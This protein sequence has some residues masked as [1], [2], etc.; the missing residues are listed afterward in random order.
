[1]PDTFT[2]NSSGFGETRVLNV[3]AA[4]HYA[5][6][7][8]APPKQYNRVTISVQGR[9]MRADH[10][11]YSCIV[12]AMSPLD[13]VISSGTRPEFGE[14]IV[15]YLEYIGRIEGTVSETG[16][17]SF[18]ISINATDRK[19]DKLSAQ[20]T[21][22]ANKQELGLP[23]D[24]RHERVVPSNTVSEIE[25]DDGSRFP[26]RIIDLSISGAAIEIQL[27]PDFGT[28][29]VLGNMRGRV[30]RHIEEGVAIEFITARPEAAINQPF[31][32]SAA[33]EVRSRS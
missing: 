27:R 11:E 20:L 18:I 3:T 17:R 29:V 15:A 1:M 28:N 21:W 25:L 4:L 19:R 31:W 23:E 16:K 8:A 2:R 10:S 5:T 7:P 32:C 9:F 6:P 24:R 22:L 14:R 26:C 30:I 12:D 13:V 33:E